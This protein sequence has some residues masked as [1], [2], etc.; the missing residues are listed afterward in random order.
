MQDF[1][2][3]GVVELDHDLF[4]C[5]LQRNRNKNGLIN[6]GVWCIEH[7]RFLQEETSAEFF[8]K[9]YLEQYLIKRKMVGLVG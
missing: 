1:D 6:G 4:Y 3:Y 7:G 5:Q 2:R 9:D 8:E